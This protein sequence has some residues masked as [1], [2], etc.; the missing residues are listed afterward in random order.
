VAVG[1]GLAVGALGHS[2]RWVTISIASVTVIVAIARV[3]VGVHWPT[4]VIGGAVV[5]F[6][7]GRAVLLGSRYLLPVTRLVL[8]LFRM[9]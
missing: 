2:R 3:Y 6:A 5:G 4:D 1:T 7:A 8:R 9:G